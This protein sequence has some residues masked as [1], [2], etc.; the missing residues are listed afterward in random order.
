MWT[1]HI[2]FLF[3]VMCFVIAI[4]MC[5]VI[6]IHSICSML[7]HVAVCCSVLQRVA[8]CCSVLQRVAVCCSVLHCVRRIRHN[9]SW[10]CMALFSHSCSVLQCVAVCCSVL[11]CVAVCCSVLQCVAVCCIVYGAI[12]HE[13]VW[14]YSVTFET[15]LFLRVTV[16]NSHIESFF[17]NLLLAATFHI[18]GSFTS[19]TR[20]FDLYIGLF[21]R[22]YVWG[23]LIHI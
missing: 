4:F 19:H 21:I 1:V 13:Y 10:V 12:L 20:S 16:L 23:F 6:A 8:V 18:Q 7:Q 14:H 9:T 5:F 3:F 2:Y 22:I 11:Q 17:V 15:L